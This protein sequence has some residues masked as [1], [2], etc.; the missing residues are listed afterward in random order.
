HR[1]A[2]PTQVIVGDY[3]PALGQC[4]HYVAWDSRGQA[5]QRAGEVE[6]NAR[7]VVLG[8]DGAG[9]SSVEV[10]REAGQSAEPGSDVV[11]RFGQPQ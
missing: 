3:L 5:C 7:L 8:S 1:D 2:V 4:Q 6:R 9:V 11:L 10:T